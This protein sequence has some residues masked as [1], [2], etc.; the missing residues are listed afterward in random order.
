MHGGKYSEVRRLPVLWNILT[1]LTLRMHPL[2]H[3]ASMLSVFAKYAIKH[4]TLY[5]SVSIEDASFQIIYMF[6][7]IL[8]FSAYSGL[9]KKEEGVLQKHQRSQTLG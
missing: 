8:L 7:N 6:Y 1:Q 2:F 3:T 5:K 4:F 9:E